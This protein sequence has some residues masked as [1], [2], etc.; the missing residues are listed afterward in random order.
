MRTKKNKS[1]GFHEDDD[2]LLGKAKK[3]SI[4]AQKNKFDKEQI[5]DAV[6]IVPSTEETLTLRFDNSDELFALMEQ[7]ENENNIQIKA[8]FE[9]E[10][11]I[12]KA[13]ADKADKLVQFLSEKGIK[14][15]EESEK[16]A[17]AEIVQS[18]EELKEPETNVETEESEKQQVDDIIAEVQSER[19]KRAVSKDNSRCRKNF[20]RIGNKA[21]K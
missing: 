13:P 8:E 4:V 17:N 19:S 6:E 20:K 10:E 18:S 16:D 12:V 15:K 5:S 2:P 3:H 1:K 9:D 7:F 11:V 21:L 14:A